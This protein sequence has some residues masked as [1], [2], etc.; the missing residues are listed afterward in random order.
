MLNVRASPNQEQYGEYPLI[1]TRDIRGID[2]ESSVEAE[3]TLQQS[4][5]PLVVLEELLELW[6]RYEC[7]I[8][9]AGVTTNPGLTIVPVPKKILLDIAL[10]SRLHLREEKTRDYWDAS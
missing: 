3:D 10:I 5:T 7:A 4:C 9:L 8:G 2:W 6:E 1:P